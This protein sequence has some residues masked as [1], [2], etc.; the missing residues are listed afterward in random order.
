MLLDILIGLKELHK[1]YIIHRDIKLKNI[2]VNSNHQ[3]V[4]GDLGILSVGS[5]AA[6]SKIGTV[7]YQAPEVYR[8]E[9]EEYDNKVDIWAIGIICYQLLNKK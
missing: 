6:M 4:L 1:I 2:F 9:Y 5:L 8:D 7:G 3:C